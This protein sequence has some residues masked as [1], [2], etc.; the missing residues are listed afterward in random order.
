MYCEKYSRMLS[1]TAIEIG[2]LGWYALPGGLYTFHDT[3]LASRRSG[4]VSHD[5]LNSALGLELVTM[6]GPPAR[7]AGSSV[8][9]SAWSRLGWVGP[10]TEQW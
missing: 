8:P 1:E 6:T 3:P 5:A 7:P 9:D 4:I 10:I 2:L